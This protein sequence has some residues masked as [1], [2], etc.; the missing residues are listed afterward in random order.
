MQIYQIL[1]PF[2]KF[3]RPCLSAPERIYKNSIFGSNSK[4]R[5]TLAKKVTDLRVCQRIRVV[6]FA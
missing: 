6:L 1:R 2:S 4:I 5:N 3:Y